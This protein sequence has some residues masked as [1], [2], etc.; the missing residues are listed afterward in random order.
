[1]KKIV[2]ASIIMF[3][4]AVVFAGGPDGPKPTKKDCIK[5]CNDA[6]AA[7][8]KACKAMPSKTKEEKK[9]K[10]QCYTDATKKG[11]DCRKP[12]K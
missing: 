7:D 2:L 4:A 12:C 11:K 6:V 9:A 5:A 10:N 3:C 8:K 1:M